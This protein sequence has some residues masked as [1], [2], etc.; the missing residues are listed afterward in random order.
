MPDDVDPSILT[1]A[2]LMHV[3]D[4]GSESGAD[5]LRTEFDRALAA[6]MRGDTYITATAFK[7]Q[8]ASSERSVNAK[9]LLAVLTQAR[10]RLAAQSSGGSNSA[11]CMLIPRFTGFPLSQ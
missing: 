7:G 11:A 2:L 4:I 10:E 3:A 8:S 5:W 1:D 6:V 9:Q